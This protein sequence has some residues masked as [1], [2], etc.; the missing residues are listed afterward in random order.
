MRISIYFVL[1]TFKYII[2]NINC[3]IWL[4]DSQF[5]V[6]ELKYFPFDRN[7]LIVS[8]WGKELFVMDVFRME[9]DNKLIEQKPQS[10]I[11]FYIYFTL[12]LSLAYCGEISD[13]SILFKVLPINF[14][15]RYYYL[16]QWIELRTIL[17]YYKRKSS[18][19]VL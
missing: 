12:S 15:F 14:R 7:H 11:Y 17:E 1:W 5:H 13:K 2:H 16:I 9:N 8:K 4:F 3:T 18:V 19:T 6:N 10:H